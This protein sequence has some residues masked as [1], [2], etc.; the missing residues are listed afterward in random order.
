L[1]NKMSFHSSF[2][3]SVCR[4]LSWCHPCEVALPWCYCDDGLCKICQVIFC[5]GRL[6]MK[7]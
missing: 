7:L 2:W 6:Y 1:I 5:H 4:W 3:S